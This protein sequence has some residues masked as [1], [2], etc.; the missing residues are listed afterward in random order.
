M[1][2]PL[3]R[4]VA[5]LP[6]PLGAVMALALFLFGVQ[7]LGTATEAAAPTLRVLHRQLVVGDASALGFGWAGAYLVGNGSVVAVL[8]LSLFEAD[9][10]TAS[11][12]FAMVAGSR[13]GAA[14]VVLLI[15][16]LDWLAKAEYSIQRSLGLGV[17]TFLVTHTVYLP[18]TALGYLAL[19]LVGDPL[20]GEG[21]G[22]LSVGLLDALDPVTAAVVGR[23]G[24]G[25]TLLVAVALLYGSLRLFDRLLATV[26]TGVIRDRFFGSF[27]RTPVAFAIGLGVTALTTSVAFSL[28]V[29]VPLYNRGYVDR[30][31]ML[32][33]VLGAN[34]G[35]LFDTLLVAVLLDSPVGVR[36]VLVLVGAAIVVTA[37]ALL[38]GEAYVARVVAADR[39]ILEDRRSLGAFLVLLL[40]VPV[41]LV[42]VPLALRALPT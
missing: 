4:L 5:R 8:S 32:P 41:A 7:L 29:V 10:L 15:G 36:A 27:R 17:L 16:G 28:G 37:V 12:L 2:R 22:G 26:D 31:E 30:E 23:L 11:Q 35:T 9:V 14:G 21:L 42:A 6:M 18:A 1:S 25:P 34:L 39:W 13:L 20:S 33:Y 40:G 24:P 3:R 38:A 19:P